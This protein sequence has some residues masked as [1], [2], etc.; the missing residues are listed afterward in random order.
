MV[1]YHHTVPT[2]YCFIILYLRG[3]LIMLTLVGGQGLV[4]R[5]NIVNG[6][7]MVNQGWALADN[8]RAHSMGMI[9]VGALTGGERAPAR[10]CR[11]MEE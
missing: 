5:R 8:V 1:L 10:S 11:S 9:G 2:R 6:H 4:E 3:T 7:P